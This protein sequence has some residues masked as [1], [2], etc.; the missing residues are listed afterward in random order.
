MHIQDFHAAKILIIDD[1]PEK[2]ELL[3]GL[4]KL[5]KYENTVGTTDGHSAALMF[6]QV[7]PDLVILDLHLRECSGF[8]VLREIAPLVG[9]DEYVP[10]LV[11]TADSSQQSREK[12]LLNGAM[13]FV[14]KPF[15]SAEIILR[16]RNLLHTRLLYLR[17][18]A[19]L[20]LAS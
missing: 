2:I 11:L 6:A 14:A 20:G 8:D 7:R 16:V 18:S 3:S 4:L 13:D 15:N 10:I 9:P 12:A 5:F 19:Q 1:E 17:L